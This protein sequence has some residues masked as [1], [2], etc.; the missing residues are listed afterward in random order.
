M[1][2]QKIDRLARDLE[3]FG[4]R[5]N[6]VVNRGHHPYKTALRPGVLIRADDGTILAHRGQDSAEFPINAVMQPEWDDPIREKRLVLV[7]E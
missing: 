7:I 1:R 2:E 6:T 4:T 5:L 3:K